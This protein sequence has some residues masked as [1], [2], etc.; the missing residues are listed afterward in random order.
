MSHFHNHTFDL[1]RAVRAGDLPAAAEALDM[2]A[3]D[4]D[5]PTPYAVQQ[6]RAAADRAAGRIKPLA[7]LP[8]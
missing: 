6:G 3:R 8:A 4:G 1:A 2:M 5:R 7:P